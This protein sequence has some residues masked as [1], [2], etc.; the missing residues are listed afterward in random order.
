VAKKKPKPS[1]GFI[2]A[3][4]RSMLVDLNSMVT[5]LA[6][7]VT[8]LERLLLKKHYLTEPEIAAMIVELH[9]E[10]KEALAKLHATRGPGGTIQ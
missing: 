9:A 5:K 1:T 3:Q 2:D 7:N 6:L 10:A 4:I 8:V